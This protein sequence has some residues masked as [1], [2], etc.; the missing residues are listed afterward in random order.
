MSKPTYNS[1]YCQLRRANKLDELMLF[2]EDPSFPKPGT[3]SRCA[4]AGPMLAGRG[5]PHSPSS[6]WRLH[7][8]P[9][10]HGFRK[11]VLICGR[12]ARRGNGLR[13]ESDFHTPLPMV[14]FT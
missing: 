5:F 12:C 6:I 10:A 9:S 4:K 11:A 8:R 14:G 7:A 13:G 2:L 1:L 3:Y